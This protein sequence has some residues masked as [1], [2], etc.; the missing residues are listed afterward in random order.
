MA[1]TA[2]S[3]TSRSSNV[4]G[5]TIERSAAGQLKAPGRSATAGH[6]VGAALRGDNEVHAAGEDDL[7]RSVEYLV[8]TAQVA[9]EATAWVTAI[10]RETADLLKLRQ[11]VGS[12]LTD[13]EATYLL[14][15][16]AFTAEQFEVTEKRVKTGVLAAQERQ[17]RMTSFVDALSAEQVGMNLGITSSRVR[18]RQ[19]K[20]NLFAFLVGRARLY[21]RWQFTDGGTKVLPHLTEVVE[22]FPDGWQPPSVDGFMKTPQEALTS[23]DGE[24]LTPPE[25]LAVGGD[26]K[27]I[28]EILEGIKQR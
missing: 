4:T 23:D 13:A 7:R 8:S 26:P 22:A 15:S 25:W 27:A 21:P 6:D 12:G 2:R 18:H 14:E 1:R 3:G 5:R 16:G 11:P 28:L 9:G 17:T 19:A 10:I 24:R 20:N